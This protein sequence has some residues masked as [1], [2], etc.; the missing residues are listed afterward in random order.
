MRGVHKRRIAKC[1][2]D[3]RPVAY[4]LLQS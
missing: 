3:K 4:K 2:V 1:K